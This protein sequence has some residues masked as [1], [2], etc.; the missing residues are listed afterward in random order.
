MGTGHNFYHRAC[1]IASGEDIVGITVRENG[2]VELEYGELPENL[3]CNWAGFLYDLSLT[4]ALVDDLHPD[5]RVVSAHLRGGYGHFVVS[6]GTTQREYRHEIIPVDRPPVALDLTHQDPSA[7]PQGGNAFWDDKIPTGFMEELR[8]TF[9]D[10]E[11][12]GKYLR[13]V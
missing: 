13:A 12:S 6:D 11:P 2:N 1:D 10:G 9:P 8:G 3:R 4:P 5:L 7:E